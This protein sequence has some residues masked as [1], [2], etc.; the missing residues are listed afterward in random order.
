VIIGL[1]A[2]PL[3]IYS[4]LFFEKVKVDDLSARERA[5]GR[6]V[7]G[8]LSVGSSRPKEACSSRRFARS[9]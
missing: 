1:L 7:F 9:P 8:T 6:G 3:T 5:P 2:G 4:V